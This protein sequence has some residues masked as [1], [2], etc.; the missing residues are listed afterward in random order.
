MA[1]TDTAIRKAKAGEKPVKLT[2]EKGLYLLLNRRPQ[3]ETAPN[4]VVKSGSK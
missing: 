4:N 2:D 3:K 1:L